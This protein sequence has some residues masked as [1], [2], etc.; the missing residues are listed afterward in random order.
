MMAVVARA[1]IRGWLVGVACSVLAAEGRA[2]EPLV[3]RNDPAGAIRARAEEVRTLMRSGRRVI[4]DGPCSS[5]C[6]MY[7]RLPPGQVCVTR[8]SALA[9]HQVSFNYDSARPAHDQTAML[10]LFYPPPVQDWIE[11]RGGL[12]AEF[13]TLAGNDLEKAAPI[14]RGRRGP[15]PPRP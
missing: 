12:R 3:V 10:L 7:L 14:C 1:V 9:F 6:T 8:R 2:A 5:A 13:I 15:A 4:I 11:A